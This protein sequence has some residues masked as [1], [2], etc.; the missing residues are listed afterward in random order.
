M[1][2]IDRVEIYPYDPNWSNIFEREALSIQNALGNNCI[3]IHHVGSTSVPGLASKLKIDIIAVVQDLVFDKGQ[4]ETLGYEYRGGFSIPLR[5]SFTIRTVDRNINLHVFEENDPEI[6]LNILFRN[7]LRE[8][9]DAKETYALLK[10]QLI[11]EESSHIKNGPMYRGY[12]LGKHDFIQHILKKCAFKRH[13]FVI[14]THHAEWDAVKAFRDKYFLD[15]YGIVDPDIWTFNHSEHVH[16]V[17][18]RGMDII[19]YA[20]M[21]WLDNHKARIK[22]MVVDDAVCDQNKV[23]HQFIALIEKWLKTLGCSL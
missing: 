7:Y 1:Q 5:R 21:Q 2:K 22:M 14:C 13:R 15:T 10:Y 18:Y 11:Q 8:H 16:L 20:H 23:K 19:S 3:A 6:E 17:L 9:A 4:L 12:T